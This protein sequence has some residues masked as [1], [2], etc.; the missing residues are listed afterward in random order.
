MVQIE[1]V[2]TKREG[3]IC[4]TWSQRAGVVLA[5]PYSVG[6]GNHDVSDLAL[7][8]NPCTHQ[9]VFAVVDHDFQM[10]CAGIIAYGVLE[11]PRRCGVGAV[12]IH[13]ADPFDTGH[14][15]TVF[16]IQ[17]VEVFFAEPDTERLDVS[18]SDV[19]I[20]QYRERI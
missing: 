19:N 5:R 4:C 20:G 10:R 3:N 18:R 11:P 14:V 17:K 9:T 13:E 16:L 15:L 7:A 8:F 12:S 2:L 1:T 6:I